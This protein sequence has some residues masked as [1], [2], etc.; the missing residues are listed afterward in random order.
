MFGHCHQTVDKYLELSGKPSESLKT[1]AATPCIDDHVIPLEE[2]EDEGVLSS[3][4]ARIVLK[5][6]M[7]LASLAM[8]SCGLSTC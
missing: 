3:K 5:L 2:F 6:C 1:K 8:T 4:A 7:S